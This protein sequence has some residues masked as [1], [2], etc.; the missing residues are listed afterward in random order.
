VP[1]VN[2]MSMMDIKFITERFEHVVH[3]SCTHLHR[4]YDC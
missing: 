4:F 1:A 2:I 3:A